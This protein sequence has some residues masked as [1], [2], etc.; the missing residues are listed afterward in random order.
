MTI[1]SEP[2]KSVP[3][4]AS[5]SSGISLSSS[6][7]K[8]SGRRRFAPE[9]SSRSRWS[10]S[11]KGG[12]VVDADHLE[13]PVA[14]QQPLV[15][16]RDGEVVRGRDPAVER[17]Q[18][19][20]LREPC[21]L[22]CGDLLRRRVTL[23]NSTSMLADMRIHLSDRA[24]GGSA[25]DQV[26]AALREA[27]VSAELEPGRRLSENELAERLGVSRTPVREALV[28]L[29]DERLVAIVPQLGTFVTLISTARRRATPP[30]CARRSSAARSAAPTE[31]ATDADLAELQANLAAQERAE[32]EGDAEA[33]DALDDA[34]HRLLCELSGHEIAWYAR[35]PRERP[36]RPRP[37]ASACPS[38]ATS[39]RWSPSTASSSR[40]VAAGDADRAEAAMRHHLRMVLSSVPQHPGGPPRL[41]R[42]VLTPWRSRTRP[43]RDD[44]YRSAAAARALRARWSSAASSR[45]RPSAS[46]RPPASAATATSPPARRRPPSAPCR[47]SSPTTCSSPATA[48]TASR[49]RAA[50]RPRRSWPSCS[51]A[52]D[53][54]AHGRGGSMHLLDVERGY[55]GGWGIVAGQLPVATGLA[56]GARAPGPP[57]GRPLRARRRR[58][59]HGRLARVAQPRRAVAAADRLPRRQQRVRDGH[60]GRRA[61]PPSPSCTSAPRRYRM[62]GERVDGDDLDAVLEAADRLLRDAREERRPA[63][64]E[65]MTYRYRGHSV[66]DAGLAYRTQG[67]DRASTRRTTRSAACARSCATRASTEDELDAID[68]AADERVAGRGRSSR[69]RA[70]SPTSTQLAAGMHAAGSA[71]QFA[72]MRP[73]SAVRRGG[74]DLRRGARA[75]ERRPPS[76]RPARRS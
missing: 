63:V 10:V 42:G 37:P 2:S 23:R 45:R 12:P 44:A 64:L 51:G 25:R 16:D 15:G 4:R 28:R 55:Y 3:P 76:R 59:E 7:R 57:A 41:L 5:S 54:C 61:P 6:L 22:P 53:G 70:R 40:R 39:A 30:S 60:R 74:A 18:L 69:S 33:F 65:A 50:S 34:L 56:L 71:E 20:R 26:Y 1:R 32:S 21:G 52:R 14:A 46:T 47:R 68:D 11:A 43:R 27:I 75:H 58:G 73:G 62:H 8:T 36:P 9:R 19:G 29:R 48:A 67:R 72:R 35:A 24:S 13:G 49:S 17:A 31:R 66:A 38:P